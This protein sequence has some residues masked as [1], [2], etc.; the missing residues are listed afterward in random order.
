MWRSA[1]STETAVLGRDATVRAWMSRAGPTAAIAHERWQIGVRAASAV[2]QDRVVHALADGHD[3]NLAV[4][5]GLMRAVT[6]FDLPACSILVADGEQ[7]AALSWGRPL[8]LAELG[9]WEYV[10]ST[11]PP[12]LA[13]GSRTAQWRLLPPGMLLVLDPCG[14]TYFP[15]PLPPDLEQT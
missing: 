8:G 4:G 6:R 1:T 10:V 3:A 13:T 5:P 9:D 14:P 2:D 15:L 11:T 7:V 12:V